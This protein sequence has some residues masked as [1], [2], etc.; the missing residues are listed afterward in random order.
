LEAKTE[1]KP[2]IL[3]K[4]FPRQQWTLKQSTK[5]FVDHSQATW[6]K[7]MNSIACLKR[8][9][10]A[11]VTVVDHDSALPDIFHPLT[12]QSSTFSELSHAIK[13]TKKKIET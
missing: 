8:R 2:N 13:A 4:W 3:V 12:V 10:L 9:E 5:K 1:A 7:E 6:K 11:V